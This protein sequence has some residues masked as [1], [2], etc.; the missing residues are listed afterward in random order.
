MTDWTIDRIYQSVP[1]QE[2]AELEASGQAVDNV[3]WLWGSKAADWIA[4]GF[5]SMSVYSAIAK[6]VGR[7]A[8]TIRQCYYTYKTFRDTL[9]NYDERIPYSVYNHAR[10]WKDP[11]EVLNYYMTHR[12][13]VDE[14]EAVFRTDSDDEPFVQTGLPRFLVGLWREMRGLPKAKYALAL[15]KVNE[16]LELIEWKPTSTSG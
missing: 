8:T 1:E 11:D 2:L 6:K 13:S 5:P 3:H 9:E 14:V 16:I 7:S 10:M 4:R 15:Q 12:A